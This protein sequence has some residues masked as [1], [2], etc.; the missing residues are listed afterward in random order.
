MAITLNVNGNN[1]S[2][3]EQGESPGWGTNLVNWASAITSGMLQKAGGS[4]TL[5]SEVDFGSSYGL[6]LPYIKSATSNP[7]SSGQVRLANADTIKYRNAANDGDLSLGCSSDALQFEGITLQPLTT[8]GD[9]MIRASG[10]NTRLAIGSEGYV[11]TVSSGIP[12]WTAAGTGDVSG[13]ASSVDNEVPRYNSTTGKIIQG[14]GITIDDTQN[15]DGLNDLDIDN[16]LTVGNDLTV[17]GNLALTGSA[18][19]TLLEQVGAL[20]PGWISNLGISL[21]SG[22]LTVVDAGGAALSGSNKGYVTM[23]STTA[24]QFSNIAVTTGSTLNDDAHASSHLTNVGFGITEASDWDEDVPFFIYVVNRGNANVDGSDGN[25]AF[26]IT[27]N[28]SMYSTPSDSDLIGDSDAAPVTDDELS[29]LMLG[30]YTQ[31]NYTSLPC[32]L[33]G[34]FRMRWSTTTDDWTIQTLGNSDG[35]GQAQLE[36]HFSK[37]WVFPVAQNGAASSTHMWSNGGTAPVFSESLFLYQIERSG[38]C[39]VMAVLNGDGGTDGAGAVSA[40]MAVPYKFDADSTFGSLSTGVV[41]DMARISGTGFTSFE[42]LIIGP[43]E[44]STYVAFA[45]S[46][47]SNALNSDFGSGSR[48]IRTKFSYKAFKFA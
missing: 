30:S 34:G 25:S 44:G 1:Y 2:F 35:I 26:F 18:N 14:S 38:M 32:Q 42:N 19:I 3:P 23:P 21:S 10:Q 47:S 39:H 12:A 13:P 29:I 28:P 46:G 4:F 40:Q 16:D 27:R 36:K 5:T 8:N 15:V 24:G 48:A 33:V 37:T 7:A 22:T 43:N 11:L 31:A 6:K 45:R 20:V 9:I 41:G 17:T